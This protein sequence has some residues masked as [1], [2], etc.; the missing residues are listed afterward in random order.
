MQ[1]ELELL[2]NTLRDIARAVIQDAEGKDVISSVMQPH[3]HLSQPGVP[4]R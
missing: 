4:P 1:Q 2:Q 3:V